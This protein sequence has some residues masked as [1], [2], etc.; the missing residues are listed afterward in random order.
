MNVLE[1]VIERV[2]DALGISPQVFLKQELYARV[3][4]ACTACG[5]AGVDKYGNDVGQSCPSC[6]AKRPK[7]ENLGRIWYNYKG[8]RRWI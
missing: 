7:V 2:K 5:A 4:R 8:N 1:R 3:I 6:G